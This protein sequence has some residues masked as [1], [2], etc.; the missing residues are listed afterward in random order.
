MKG[1]YLYHYAYH[2]YVTAGE[3]AVGGFFG[4]E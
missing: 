4:V 3:N 1:S 2:V